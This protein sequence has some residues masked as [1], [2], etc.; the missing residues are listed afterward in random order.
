MRALTKYLLGLSFILSVISVSAKESECKYSTY[1]NQII[2]SFAKSMQKELNLI[3][4]GS[5]GQMPRDVEI[6]TVMFMFNRSVSVD[7]ARNL[8]VLATNEFLEKINNH[9][10]VRPFLREFPFKSDRVDVSI[11]FI[12]DNTDDYFDGVACANLVKGSIIYYRFDKEANDLI[13]IAIEPYEEALKKF[14]K[15]KGTNP[16]RPVI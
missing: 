12:D 9:Q 10:E 11:S 6:I 16:D 4:V 14:N 2:K 3:C 13:E 5:G 7:E 15:S 8:E 1:V